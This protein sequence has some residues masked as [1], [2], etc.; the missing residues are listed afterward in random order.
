VRETGSAALTGCLTITGKNPTESPNG[1]PAI[2]GAL[3]GISRMWL[4]FQPVENFTVM[5]FLAMRAKPVSELGLRMIR[6]V[7]FQLGSVTGVV[8]DAFAEHANG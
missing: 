6:Y 5:L 2:G 7:R 8:S 4:R 1:T 3:S